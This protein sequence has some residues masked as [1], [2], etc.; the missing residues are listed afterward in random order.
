RR[1]C[2]QAGMD[3]AGRRAELAGPPTGFPAAA[4]ANR[5]NAPSKEPCRLRAA[6]DDEAAEAGMSF[7]TWRTESGL[8]VQAVQARHPDQSGPGI[9]ILASIPPSPVF[10]ASGPK[11]DSSPP[12][13]HDYR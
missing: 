8:A 2:L 1:R 10:P 9:A 3:K 7:E 6:S 4:G 11:E 5:A 13:L 12:G